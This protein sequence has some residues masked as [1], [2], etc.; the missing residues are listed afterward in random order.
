KARVAGADLFEALRAREGGRPLRVFFFGGREGS[1]EAA[2]A[3]LARAPG[4]LEAAGWLNPG[5]GDVET[6]ST[7]D[8]LAAI[9]AAAPDFVV[10]SLGAAKGQAWIE[11]NGA[12][13]KAPVIAHLGAVVDFTAG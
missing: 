11:R 10:V 1:A 8:I 2:H 3:A 13:L 12:R 7:D 4:G 6:M 5:F 9:D